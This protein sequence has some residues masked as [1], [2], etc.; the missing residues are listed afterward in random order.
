MPTSPKTAARPRSLRNA[1][2]TF[3]QGFLVLSAEINVCRVRRE[4]ERPFF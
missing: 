1:E 3:R 2:L 4:A